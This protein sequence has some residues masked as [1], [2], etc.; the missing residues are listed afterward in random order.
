VLVKVLDF[1]RTQAAALDGLVHRG[2]DRILRREPGVLR[3]P[4]LL[5]PADPD[6]GAA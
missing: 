2:A 1:G 6:A 3:G 5:M 4:P